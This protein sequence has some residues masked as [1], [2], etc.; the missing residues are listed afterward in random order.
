VGEGLQVLVTLS[1]PLALPLELSRVRLRFAAEDETPLENGGAA[2]AAAPCARASALLLR[3]CMHACMQSF[4]HKSSR[5]DK[6]E[7]MVRS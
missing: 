4:C 7:M 1:N 2:A 5:H 6:N 3:T